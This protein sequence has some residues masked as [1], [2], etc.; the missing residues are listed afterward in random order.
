MPAIKTQKV[1]AETILTRYAN[2]VAFASSNTPATTLAEFIPQL[3][4]AIDEL[5]SA[6]ITG[7]FALNT[8]IPL[9]TEALAAEDDESRQSFID[10]ATRRLK[11]LGD[12]VDEFRDMV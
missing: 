5:Q 1:T 6:G 12:A 7:S 10:A 9:L 3:D 11:N 2:D 8:A 4:A